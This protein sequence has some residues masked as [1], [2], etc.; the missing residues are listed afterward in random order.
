M[1][2]KN[3]MPQQAQ[4]VNRIAT[5]QLPSELAELSEEALSLDWLDSSSVLPSW[6]DK[7]ACGNTW[8]DCVVCS[9]DG[10]DAE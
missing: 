6:G 8:G 3:L 4:P 1:D 7:Y 9:Y 10:E 2:N 5:G